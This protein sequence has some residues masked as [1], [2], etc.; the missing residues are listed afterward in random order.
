MRCN[1]CKKPM[2]LSSE[3]DKS[4]LGFSIGFEVS[5]VILGGY[6]VA[7]C[8]SSDFIKVLFGSAVV[9]ALVGAVLWFFVSGSEVY[10]KD[11]SRE[12]P[13]S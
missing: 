5:M 10:C 7:T 6:A 9:G 4:V 11:C 2:G 13:M 8:F 12:E 3:E 1:T